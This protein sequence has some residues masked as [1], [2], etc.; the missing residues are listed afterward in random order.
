MLRDDF[1]GQ[2]SRIMGLQPS[3][4]DPDQPLNA[5]GL[6]SLMAIELKNQIET[7]LGITLPMAK[8]MEGPS[9]NSLADLVSELLH[10]SPEELP[11][12]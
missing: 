10:P 6:D 3:N 1:I 2:L 12:T 8:F 4:L 11:S 5:I 9:V 7:R